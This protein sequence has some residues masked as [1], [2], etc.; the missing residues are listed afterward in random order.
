M[1]YTVTNVRLEAPV[2][3]ALKL[4]ALERGVPTAVLIREAIA[5]YLDQAAAPLYDWEK[6]R[7]ELLKLCGIGRSGGKR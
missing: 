7:A 5:A 6:E 4:R 2:F 3:R 1:E